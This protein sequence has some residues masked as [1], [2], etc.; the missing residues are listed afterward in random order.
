LF[1]I[2][3]ICR[4]YNAWLNCDACLRRLVNIFCCFEFVSYRILRNESTRKSHA[5]I[6]IVNKLFVFINNIIM[7][8]NN[9]II[10]I[11]YIIYRRANAC[12]R[13]DYDY[14]SATPHT[15]ILL[16]MIYSCFMY[17]YMYLYLFIKFIY[18]CNKTTT[19]N[20]FELVRSKQHPF[21]CCCC[22]YYCC[23]RTSPRRHILFSPLTN[24]HLHIYDDNCNDLL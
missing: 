17:T 3:F 9:F 24:L 10:Y 15:C 11:S 19:H 14:P 8:N 16:L 7:N 23:V 5:N 6:V 12:T 4:L 2:V 22:Y 21:W 20:K 1:Y 13:S 18:M